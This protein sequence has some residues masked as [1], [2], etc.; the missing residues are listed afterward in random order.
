MVR[1]RQKVY[2]LGGTEN[3]TWNSEEGGRRGEGGERKGKG[4]VR[5]GGEGGG[6]RG[7]QVVNNVNL[8]GISP[9]HIRT[10]C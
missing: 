7:G 9:L 1:W 8:D 5:E 10:S 2:N 6:E 3:S 4:K